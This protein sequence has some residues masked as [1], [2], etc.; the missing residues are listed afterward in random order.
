MK[1][2]AQLKA[3]IKE[4]RE[5]IAMLAATSLR[6]SASLDLSTVLHE[7][8]ECARTLI[9]ARIAAIVTIGSSGQPR[10]FVTAGISAD[11][12]RELLDSPDGRQLFE[13]L[14]DIPEV[15]RLSDLSSFAQARGLSVDRLPSSD[16]LAMSLRHQGMHLGNFFV[17]EKKEGQEFSS[18]DE[19]ILILF[20][21]QAAAAIANARTHR[22]ERRA[23]ANLEALVE[24]SPV[25]VFVCDSGSGKVES[26]NREAKRICGRLCKPGES[27][28]ELPNIMTVRRPDGRVV[29]L[30]ELSLVKELSEFKIMQ[31]EEVVL[32]V[33]DGRS[34]RTLVNA[35]PIRG[36]SGSVESVV[37]TMQDLAPLEELERLRA[38]FLGM[39]SHELRAPLAAIKGS[40]ATVLSA[41]SALDPAEVLQFFRIVEEQADQMHGLI[42]DLLDAGRIEAGTLSVNPETAEVSELVEKARQTFIGSGRRNAIQVDFPPDLPLVLADRQRIVQVLNN[43]FLNASNH[44]PESS[45]IRVRAM[46]DGTYLAIS[47]IDEG[48]GVPPELLPQL[49]RKHARLG[50]DREHGM[51]GSGLGLAICK[52]LVEAHGGR[53]FAESGGEGLG[54]RFTF[55]LPTLEGQRSGFVPRLVQSHG[56]SNSD[57]RERAKILVVDDDPL[58]L[59][60]VRD[61]LKGAGYLTLVTAEPR[62]VPR[63]VKTKKPHLVLLDLVLPGRDGIE[64]MQSIPELADIPVI[65][66][67]GYMRDETAARALEAGAT[68]YLVK[69]FSSTELVARVQAALRGKADMPKALRIRD[70]VIDYNARQVMLAGCPVQ[71]TATEFDLL[72]ELS[73]NAGKVSTYDTLLRRV[74]RQSTGDPRLVRAFVKNLRKKL[75]DDATRPVFIFNVRQVGYRMAIPDAT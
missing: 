36:E 71:L 29:A 75:G 56:R 13:H 55:T 12:H 10:N 40:A 62:D 31:A 18:A 4:L 22:A 11:E 35:M 70:L 7:V 32:E 26:F 34:V 58:M 28:E 46:Q 44:S 1:N 72:Q 52:G 25:G 37:V 60:Y 57:G 50:R 54:T 69:P 48:R 68:D 41:S 74:W 61:A 64:L 8:A 49:F 2:P 14:R 59:R 42:S 51:L 39:V 73:L 23:R 45:P 9:G 27:V 33:P 43:L 53:I 38:E 63:L 20:A 17:T 3:E 21:S 19:E 6:L 67:S 15:L 30:T 16:F 47:V 66:I 24:T 65:F 5:R